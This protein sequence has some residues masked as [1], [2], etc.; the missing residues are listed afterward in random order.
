MDELD[1]IKERYTTKYPL[2]TFP[3]YLEEYNNLKSFAPN[4]N[5]HDT[6]SITD[7]C[8]YIM[9]LTT[10]YHLTMAFKSMR[11]DLEDPNVSEMIEEGNIGTPGRIAKVWC[12]AST[13]DDTELGGGRWSKN[14]RLADFPSSNTKGVVPNIP[15]T[16][17]VDLISNCSHHFIPFHT[18]AREDSYAVISY[19]PKDFKL[20][21]SKLQRITNHVAQ[22]FWLQED[23]TDKLYTEI[24]EAAQTEDVYVGLFN[25]VHGCESLR[26]A[27]SEDGTFTSEAYG[28]KFSDFEL[29]KQVKGY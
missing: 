6:Q 3:N 18:K 1:F 14:P 19:I 11:I 15:I 16:K 2:E 10:Q 13:S 28:G 12:G 27:R 29:R 5:V 17:R 22:R 7:Q 26:G 24:S 20:G 9:R 21:I 8:H 23:L 25:V 4:G